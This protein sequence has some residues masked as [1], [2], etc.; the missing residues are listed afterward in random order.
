MKKASMWASLRQ[1]VERFE[2]GTDARWR[3]EYRQAQYEK[4]LAG[5]QPDLFG[6][7]TIEHF[8]QVTTERPELW[9]P[10][11]EVQWFQDLSEEQRLELLGADPQ[12]PFARTTRKAFS[13]AETDAL[14][15]SAQNWLR[16]GQRVRVTGSSVSFDGE[17]EKR[18]GRKGTIWRLCSAAFS[19][20]VYV[21]LDPLRRERSEKVAFLEIR[22]IEPITDEGKR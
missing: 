22:D 7:P 15:A 19:D 4:R 9:T 20:R 1:D 12:T 14:V 17:P 16:L 13:K 11:Y 10:N 2:I 5:V 18:V 6:G 21:N 8:H 3:A